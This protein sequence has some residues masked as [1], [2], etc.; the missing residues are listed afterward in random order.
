MESKTWSSLITCPLPCSR[1]GEHFELHSKR[2]DKGN[3]LMEHSVVDVR[4]LLGAKGFSA[5]I[6]CRLHY[7]T[8]FLDVGFIVASSVAL[9]LL[10]VGSNDWFQGT[11]KYGVTALIVI[12]VYSVVGFHS[13]QY[14]WR[15]FRHH[16]RRPAVAFGGI[17][18]AFGALL[19]IGFA[20]KITDHYSRLWMGLWFISVALYI[21]VSRLVLTWYLSSPAQRGLMT[22]QAIIVGAGENGRDVLDHILRFDDLGIRVVGFLDD[23]F[24]RLA[25]SY[26]GVR[27]LGRTDLI[28]RLVREEGPDLVIMALPWSAHERIKGLIKKL[29]T[30]AVDIYMAPDKLGLHYADRPV[31]R[32]GGMHVLSLEDR[33]ISEWNA[34]VKRIEDLCIAVPALILL[35]PLLVL[36]ALAIKL[37]SKGDVF[38]VQERQGFKNNLIRVYKFR[39]MYTDMT[40]RSCERQTV[41]DDP[42]ITR[43]G[44]FIRK[45]SIDELPQLFNVLLGNMSVVGPRPHA[46]GTKSEGR[47]L[48]EVVDEYASRHRVKPGITGWAQCNGW[49]G[50]TDTAEKIQK[51]VEHDLYY[52]ENWSVFLDLLTILKTLML[53]AKKDENAY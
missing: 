34:V 46:T 6:G 52:I 23:R 51:R 4:P 20:L 5:R 43:V 32:V 50:E 40:D 15:K 41:K 31:F 1:A 7:V 2:E 29:S 28:E 42:R 35:S 9:W 13:G 45:T 24:G 38:F 27:L 44:R 21:V 48:E 53:L 47:L 30:W 3:S 49:R 8:Y 11:L 39:S 26:R 22:R 18:F 25:K 19:I 12:T 17:I 36:V 14:D 10:V 16:V 33:P 37:E